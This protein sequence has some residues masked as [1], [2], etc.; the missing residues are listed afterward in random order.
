VPLPDAPYPA[1]RTRRETST[2]RSV[3]PRLLLVAPAILLACLLPACTSDAPTHPGSASGIALTSLPATTTT[4]LPP[5]TT[6]TTTT[7]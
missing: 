4:T 5:T 3:V 1:A 6:T 7:T 2:S